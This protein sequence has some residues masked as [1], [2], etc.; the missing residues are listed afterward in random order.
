M[1]GTLD[2]S[3][4][5]VQTWSQQHGLAVSLVYAVATVEGLTS[6]ANLLPGRRGDEAVAVRSGP[7]PSGSRRAC[8][9][10]RWRQRRE[11][12][13]DSRPTPRKGLGGSLRCPRSSCCGAG[14]ESSPT[15]DDCAPWS[16][17]TAGDGFAWCYD[18]SWD[19]GGSDFR[20]EAGVSLL[21]TRVRDGPDSAEDL[22]DGMSVGGL[23]R[24]AYI[25]R[26]RRRGIEERSDPA[27]PAQWVSPV[28]IGHLAEL[29]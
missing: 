6:G 7:L 27:L 8:P 24:H 23:I 11:R 1:P 4:G 29:T 25:H 17:G 18:P 21:H 12:D 20:E 5:E 10:G 26:N 15:V 14:P 19:A 16:A 22:A 9:S 2:P 28:H 3:I 13:R